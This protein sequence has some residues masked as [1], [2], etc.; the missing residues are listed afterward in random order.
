ML[1]AFMAVNTDH[2]SIGVR[3]LE[4]PDSDEHQVK[5][6]ASR[7]VPSALNRR[8]LSVKKSDLLRAIERYSDNDKFIRILRSRTFKT[9]EDANKERKSMIPEHGGEL[10]SISLSALE[11]EN[12]RKKRLRDERRRSL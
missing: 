8:E 5:H 12:Q 10:F 6:L 7:C 11:Q 2:Q 1:F 4:P 3:Q 9:K